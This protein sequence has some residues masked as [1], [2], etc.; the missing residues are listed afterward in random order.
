[1]RP[2]ARAGPPSPP[3]GKDEDGFFTLLGDDGAGKVLGE[4]QAGPTV[5][6]SLEGEVGEVLAAE[7][8]GPS[9]TS[10][11]DAIMLPVTLKRAREE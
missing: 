2:Q 8:A 4:G 10:G 1:M 7:Q 9:V 3:W 5:P 11:E 6:P